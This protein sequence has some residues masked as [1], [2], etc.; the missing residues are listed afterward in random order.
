MRVGVDISLLENKITG[1]SLGFYVHFCD[2]VLICLVIAPVKCMPTIITAHFIED[3]LTVRLIIRDL[4]G[5]R[6]IVYVRLI[7]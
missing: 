6:G 4:L 2:I 7:T 5:E 3:Q 1:V